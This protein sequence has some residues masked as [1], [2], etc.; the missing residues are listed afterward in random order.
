MA[1]LINRIRGRV[2]MTV[3]DFRNDSRFSVRLAI[4]HMMDELCSRFGPKTAASY[5]SDRKHEWIM[6]YLR[7][8]LR[9]VLDEFAEDRDVGHPQENA[10]IW[11]CWWTGEETAPEL[12]KQCIRSI[13]AN[14]GTHPVHLITK[15][16]YVQF[17]SIPEYI[18]EKAEH[19]KIKNAHLAD[20]IRVAL[21]ADH[22]GLWLD[23]TI[24]CNGPVPDDCFT[25]SFFTCKD[26]IPSGN[27]ISRMQWTTFL[28]GGWQGNVFFRCL[29]AAFEAYWTK[30]E[31]AVNYLF[32]DC[33]IALIRNRVP[34]CGKLLAEV[35]AN[36]PHRDDLQAAMNNAIP[37]EAWSS[38]IQSDTIFYKLSWRENYRETTQDGQDSIY[39]YFLNR[40]I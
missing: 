28:L 1:N 12:V 25:I 5:F 22:G 34:A 24:F 32:F 29:K 7:E 10:P 21:L 14:A 13:R 37:A 30:E 9:D 23:S 40:E 8:E 16:N 38:V 2:K 27:Y 26:K 31:S 3:T 19:G 6:D 20:Y 15:E 39:R 18:L 11:V 36:N 35:S 17:L 4:F 33:L